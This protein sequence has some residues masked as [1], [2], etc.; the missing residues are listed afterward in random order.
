MTRSERFRCVRW[1]LGW[2]PLVF[3]VYICI[4]A[5]RYPKSIE[6]PLSY[7]LNLSPSTFH[8]KKVKKLIDAW[9]IHWPSICAIL[10]EM[11]YLASL[12]NP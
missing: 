8:T 10:L 6:D 11:N 7:L 2:L 4:T 12:P 5:F 1:R 3:L 9:L